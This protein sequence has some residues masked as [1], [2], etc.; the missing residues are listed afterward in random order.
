MNAFAI[1]TFTGARDNVPTMATHP[2]RALVEMLAAPMVAA[3]TVETCGL[4]EHMR[5]GKPGECRWKYTALWGPSIYPTG[6]TRAA[7]NVEAVSLLAL[8]VDHTTDDR[9]DAINSRLSKLRCLVH[10]SHRDRPGDRR[11]RLVIALSRPVLASEWARFW[12][13]AVDLL[14]VPADKAARDA[15]RIYF[16]PSRPSD[17]GYYFVEHAGEPLDVEA[18]LARPIPTPAPLLRSVPATSSPSDD[19]RYRR[20]SKYLAT[21]P[22][23]VSGSHGHDALFHAVAT[24]MIGFDLSVSD[25]ERLIVDEFNPRCDPPWSAREI[26]HKLADVAAKSTRERGYLLV[27][28]PTGDPMSSAPS[29]KGAEFLASINSATDTTPPPEPGTWPHALALAL[30]DV[31][32]ALGTTKGGATHAPLFEDAVGLLDRQFTETPWLVTGL[33]TRGGI[34]TIGAE[35]KA[36]KTW[37]ATELA[38]AVATGTKACGEFQA[39]PGRVAYFYAEDLPKQVRNRVRALLVGAGRT[40]EPGRLSVQPRGEFLDVTRDADLAR[41]VASC[42][43]FGPIDLLV[44]DPLRDISSAAE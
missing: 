29:S 23:S 41:I 22:A 37:L 33:V 30:A 35:P 16:L 15:S 19:Q 6:A 13:S 44:L 11:V 12:T 42:R 8:D 34:T 32:Q 20:A 4:G 26:D 5:D 24:V 9:L 2:W 27:D 17:A 7:G 21:L 10:A 1:S 18:V 28:D 39:A 36:S 3:C 40:L 31:C 38:V 25:T 14:D 43:Q